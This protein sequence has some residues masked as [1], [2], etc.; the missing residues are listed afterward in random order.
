MSSPITIRQD[1][2]RPPRPFGVSLAIIFTILL[3]TVI[4]LLQVG[5]LFIIRQRIYSA[6]IEDGLQPI[7]LGGGISGVSDSTL[8]LRGTFAL[9]FLIIA[10]FAWRGRPPAIRRILIAA[11]LL[12]TAIRLIEIIAQ[13]TQQPNLESGFNSFDSILQVLAAGQFF[14][15]LLLLLYVAWYMN[16][17]SARAFFRGYYLPEELG[18]TYSR[19]D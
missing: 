14:A 6:L 13:A 9:T 2:G 3:F 1:S 17:A 19:L 15:D 12:L 11:V 18:A 7:A 16:R 5:E 4:P 10:I 8:F